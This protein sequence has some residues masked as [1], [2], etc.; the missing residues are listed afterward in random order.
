MVGISTAAVQSFGMP[1]GGRSGP[2]VGAVLGGET[3]DAVVLV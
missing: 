2:A 1:G 3:D